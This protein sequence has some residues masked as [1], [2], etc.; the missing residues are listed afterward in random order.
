[1]SQHDFNIAN[2]TF[3]NTRADINDAILAVVSNSSGDTEPTTTYANQWWYETD[4]NTLKIRNEANDGWV[5]VLT[6][7]VSMT[8]T[9]T[10]LNKL[11]GATVSTAELN[12]LSGAT[13]TTAE[14]N[15]L[16]GATISTAEL[17]LINGATARGTDALA[18]G[19]GMLIND[20]GT[21]RMTKVETVKEYMSAGAGAGTTNAF[22]N[23]NGYTG[24]SIRD[25]GGVSSISDYGLGDFGVNFS[26]TQSN[27]NYTTTFGTSPMTNHPQGSA[28]TQSASTSQMRASFGNTGGTNSMGQRSDQAATRGQV[29]ITQ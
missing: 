11:D 16:N 5:T 7:D 23:F 29:V 19:D 8:S 25:S 27:A 6:L 28:S 20:A 13:V 22:V 3:P 26:P 14:L 17:N 21:M 1:M 18:D 24:T 12:K 4:T 2:Q 10:E 9:A 15:K